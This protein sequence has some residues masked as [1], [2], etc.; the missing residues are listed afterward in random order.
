MVLAVSFVYG[1]EPT[2]R[3]WGVTAQVSHASQ[4]VGGVF[5]FGRFMIRP[6]LW[7]LGSTFSDT[8]AYGLGS[9]FLLS[10]QSKSN[11]LWYFGPSLLSVV[12][13]YIPNGDFDVAMEIAAKLGVQ[14]RIAPNVAVYTDI[15]LLF[16]LNM[17]FGTVHDISFD[18][19]V[20]SYGL[21]AVI[22]IK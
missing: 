7:S 6:G 2:D 14:A 17:L 1:E 11:L 22:Y 12:D 3:S 9:D 5:H 19:R 4:W 10:G 16:I 13:V 15:G 18:M 20:K 21:G 8:I